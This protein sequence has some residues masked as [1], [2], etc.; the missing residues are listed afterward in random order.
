MSAQVGTSAGQVVVNIVMD[1]L[2]EGDRRSPGTIILGGR[3]CLPLPP[4][5]ICWSRRLVLYVVMDRLVDRVRDGMLP[6]G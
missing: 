2:M 3:D 4:T 5:I 6:E 1:Q